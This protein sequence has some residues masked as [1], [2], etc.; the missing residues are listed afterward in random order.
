M[1]TAAGG[2]AG[3][4]QP[5][6]RRR[7]GDGG[8]KAA[9]A[10]AAA[11]AAAVGAAAAPAPDDGGGKAAA[12]AA[13]AP[14]PAAKAAVDSTRRLFPRVFSHREWPPAKIFDSTSQLAAPYPDS[15]SPL[16]EKMSQSILDAITLQEVA[17]SDENITAIIEQEGVVNLPAH[18]LEAVAGELSV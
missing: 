5:G 1:I 13:P 17:G 14:P 7:G 3:A 9:A 10:A 15:Y 18:V 4:A 2:N 12:A 16:P 8:D 11:G 6:R